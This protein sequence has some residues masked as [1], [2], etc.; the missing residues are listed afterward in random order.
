MLIVIPALILGYCLFA[1]IWLF[2]A[3]LANQIE[4]PRPKKLI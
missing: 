4:N 2:I 3:C 1:G